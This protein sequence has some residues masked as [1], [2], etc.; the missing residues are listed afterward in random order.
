[1]LPSLPCWPVATP[2]TT[3]LCASIILPITPPALL[4]AAA[5]T[6]ATPTCRAVICCKPPN[7]TLEEVSLP[8]RATPSQPS[9]GEKNGKQNAGA[10]KSQ[11]H[12]GVQARIAG[13]KAQ[14]QHGADGQQRFADA[15]QRSQENPEQVAGREAQQQ[16]ADTRRQQQAGAGGGSPVE[17]EDG[18]FGGRLATT[19]GVRV[20]ALCSTGNRDIDGGNA[21]QEIGMS[22]RPPFRKFFT[23]VRPPGEYEHRE[24]NPGHPGFELSAA[25]MVRRLACSS[26]RRRGLRARKTRWWPAARTSSSTMSATMETTEAPMAASEAPI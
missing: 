14:R 18:R 2:A 16:A 5:S 13:G 20:T 17:D 7:S 21:A 1:M 15:L 19:G 26:A 8:V 25:G 22:G 11:P 6:G 4:A 9:S 23:G 12:G 3:M 24:Q 10:G